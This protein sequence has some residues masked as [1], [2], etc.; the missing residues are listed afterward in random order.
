VQFK[1]AYA[2]PSRPWEAGIMSEIGT[3]GWTGSAFPGAL[4]ED[5]YAVVG[6]YVMKDPRPGSP[7]YRFE[8]QSSTDNDTGYLLPTVRGAFPAPSGPTHGSWM[9]GSIYQTI[10][11][12]RSL[13]NVTYFHTNSSLAPLGSPFGPFTGFVGAGS[14]TTA[15]ELGLSYA[16]TPYVRVYGKGSIVHDQR[17]IFSL[18]FWLTPPLRDRR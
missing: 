1:A 10:L 14:T 12:N 9:T 5:R 3:Y 2:D 7:G 6:P 4:H 18:T 17:P 16:I 11:S 8:Y 13:V 15:G